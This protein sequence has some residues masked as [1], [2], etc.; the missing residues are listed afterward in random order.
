MKYILSFIAACICS[1]TLMAGATREELAVSHIPD[2]LVHGAHSVVRSSETTLDISSPAEAEYTEHTIVT[3][4]DESAA[5]ELSIRLYYDQF[6]KIKDMKVMLYDRNGKLMNKHQL[7]D[8]KDY[9]A[10]DGFSLFNDTRVKHLQTSGGEY[11]VTIDLTV[12]TGFNGVMEYPDWYIQDHGQS[13]ERSTLTVFTPADLGIGYKAYNTSIKPVISSDKKEYTWSVTGLKAYRVP[14]NSYSAAYYL[15]RVD[16]SP[17]RFQIEGYKGSFTSWKTF[18]ATL[19]DMWK[20]KRKLPDNVQ[21]EVKDMVKNAKNEREKVT[22][23]YNYLQKNFRYVSVQIGMGGW[24][25]FDATTVHNTKYGDCKALSNYMCA[26]LNTV[27][28]KAHPVLINAGDNQY[29]ID[30]TFPSN[31]FNHAILYSEADGKPL[32][33]ECTSN[34]VPPGEL[35]IF[36][37]NR[38]GLMIGDDGGH[39]LRTP[40]SSPEPNLVSVSHEVSGSDGGINING[41]VD[42]SGEYRGGAKPRLLLGT[43]KEQMSYIFNSLHLKQP[44]ETTIDPPLDS[45]Y[46]ISVSMHGKKEHAYDFKTGTKSFFSSTYITKWYDNLAVDSNN[47]YDVLVDFPTDKK[48]SLT[49]HLGEGNISL[50]ADFDLDNKVVSF[51]RKSAKTANNTVTIH[52]E[53]KTKEYIIHPADIGLLKE[54]LQKVNKYIQQKVIIEEK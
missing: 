47:K 37:E 19:A 41:T 39:I 42:L 23:L 15:P 35:G 44:E 8:M 29:A 32:W 9:A 52:T 17:V 50:P 30:T 26:L 2:S 18:G 53:L 54:S 36:T 3:V 27:G 1:I 16:L 14:A 33:L 43:Q 22:I 45:A 48:E 7:S 31:R 11:P 10:Y 28:V 38:Y 51:H 13:L 49:Y 4:L 20:D 12:V 25:P 21:A 40:V 6:R 34:A 24:I 46:H 5:D